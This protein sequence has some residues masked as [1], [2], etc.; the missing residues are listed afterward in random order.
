MPLTWLMQPTQPLCSW[1]LPAVPAGRRHL[2]GATSEQ[3]VKNITFRREMKA[4]LIL[5]FFFPSEIKVL[6]S[7]KISSSSYRI[8]ARQS[9]SASCSAPTSWQEACPSA[10]HAGWVNSV[11]QP[12]DPGHGGRHMN[13]EGILPRQTHT[14]PHDAFPK[15]QLLTQCE[16]EPYLLPHFSLQAISSPG[17]CCAHQAAWGPQRGKQSCQATVLCCQV[18]APACSYSPGQVTCTHIWKCTCGRL[19]TLCPSPDVFN[20]KPALCHCCAFKE[21]CVSLGLQ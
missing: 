4:S 6:M 20:S 10:V 11:A 2:L 8:A 21:P 5:A 18:V 1:D 3:A 9:L 16:P 12:A 15:A 7:K 14:V 19:W 17:S 13:M